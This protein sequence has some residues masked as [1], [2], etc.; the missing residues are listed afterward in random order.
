MTFA[1]KLVEE[2]PEST[3]NLLI[4][5]RSLNRDRGQPFGKTL[6]ST[7]SNTVT[8]GCIIGANII[9]IAESASTLAKSATVVTAVQSVQSSVI[10]VAQSSSQASLTA[11]SQLSAAASVGAQTGRTVT[12]VATESAE[13]MQQSVNI[14]SE[15]DAFILAGTAGSAGTAGTAGATGEVAA[16]ALASVK[17]AASPA[18]QAVARASSEGAK[19]ASKALYVVG[20][21]ALCAGIVLFTFEVYD[22]N[23]SWKTSHPS[24]K[25][26]KRIMEELRKEIDGLK[27]F[28]N[29][30]SEIRAGA[31]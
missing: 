21:V 18:G 1:L 7:L 23:R 19:A 20:G 22:L 14:V 29:L 2:W 8:S 15:S 12:H 6:A 26:A 25:E 4:Y 31:A 13:V 28:F 5:I 24:A 11:V 27:N 10:K 30:I 17:G 3:Q 9:K 16:S